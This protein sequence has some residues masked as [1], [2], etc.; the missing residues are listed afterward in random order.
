M[1]EVCAVPKDERCLRLVWDLEAIIPF[2]GQSCR[3]LCS[4]GQAAIGDKP[5]ASNFGK[6]NVCFH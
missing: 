3:K 6:G 5:D 4:L 2:V 1:K